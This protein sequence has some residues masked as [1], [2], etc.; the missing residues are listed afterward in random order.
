MDGEHI[1]KLELAIGGRPVRLTVRVPPGPLALVDLLPLAQ[2]LTDLTVQIAS[3]AVGTSAR[4]IRCGP[5]CG[6]CCRQLVPISPPE[7][8]RLRQTIEALAPAHR[9]RVLA[10]FA[11][12]ARQLA[13]SGLTARLRA[14]MAPGTPSAAARR[15]LGLDYFAQGIACPFLEDE[16]CSIHAERPL[17]CREYLVTSAPQHCADPAASRAEVVELPRRVSIA[18]AALSAER[19]RAGMAAAAP[20]GADAGADAGADSIADAGAPAGGHAAA[21]QV[22]TGWPTW[23]ALIQALDEQLLDPAALTADAAA[24]VGLGGAIPP[25]GA[26]LFQ[27]LLQRLT[28]ARPDADASSEPVA[29]PDPA[30]ILPADPGLA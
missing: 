13:A 26:D 4:Q 19:W 25:D 11:A 6:A 18:F 9:S 23:L 27:D 24:T 3:E 1:F 2:G 28:A 20:P 30:A 15:A 8:L 29:E 17:A 5:R 14:T 10:R 16:S 12:S 22:A 21:A 7:A